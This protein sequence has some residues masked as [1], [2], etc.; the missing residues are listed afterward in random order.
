[1][2]SK[3]PE[4]IAKYTEYRKRNTEASS[5]WRKEK[6]AKELAHAEQSA[7]KDKKV[8]LL[9]TN[10][11]AIDCRSKCWSKR[12]RRRT[13]HMRRRWPRRTVWQVW[14]SNCVIIPHV[15]IEAL[16]QT[17]KETNARNKQLEAQVEFMEKVSTIA[18]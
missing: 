2:L 6:K 8:C 10:Y 7:A 13:W 11:A 3:T 14:Y 17:L 18:G 1:M 5:L 12:G 4:E 9:F 16:Q 15:Q